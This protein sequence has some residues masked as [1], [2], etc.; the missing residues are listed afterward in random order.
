[1]LAAR[2]FL[3]FLCDQGQAAEDDLAQALAFRERCLGYGNAAQ[4][5]I[6]FADRLHERHLRDA[7][8]KMLHA[9]GHCA[10]EAKDERLAHAVDKRLSDWDD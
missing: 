2:A 5:L 8:R 7:A 3:S 9:A 10:A 1:V 6:F 4:W